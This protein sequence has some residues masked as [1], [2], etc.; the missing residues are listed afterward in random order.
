MHVTLYTIRQSADTYPAE[1]WWQGVVQYFR[2]CGIKYK[3]S[4][5]L[6]ALQPRGRTNGKRGRAKEV[7]VTVLEL[8]SDPDRTAYSRALPGVSWWTLATV[9]LKLFC[10]QPLTAMPGN[11]TVP[12]V[13]PTDSTP[14]RFPQM[15]ANL[16][17]RALQGSV[18]PGISCCVI[19]LSSKS[20]VCCGQP[21]LQ[22]TSWSGNI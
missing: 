15:R 5:Y 22:R 20:S 16:T 19:F 13:L 7:L 6:C 12:Q 11:R 4:V 18:E 2:H 8:C 9:T 1:I 3:L 17:Q 21:C 14:T 10:W